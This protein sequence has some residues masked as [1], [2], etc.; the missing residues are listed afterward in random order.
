MHVDDHEEIRAAGQD[1]VAAYN[2]GQLEP[3]SFYTSACLLVPP[4]G[5]IISGHKG[6]Q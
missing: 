1:L 6:M 3:S 5:E 4:R 2:S